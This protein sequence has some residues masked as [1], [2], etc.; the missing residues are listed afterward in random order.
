MPDWLQAAMARLDHFDRF[1]IAA[2]LLLMVFSPWLIQKVT[3][4]S[5]AS[6]RG[7]I[8]I[9][10]L[11]S[12]GLLMLYVLSLFTDVAVSAQCE[13]GP[14]AGCEPL[15]RVSLT[16]LTILV[17]YAAYIVLHA[18]IVRRFGRTRQ[19]EDQKVVSRTY[20]SELFSLLILIG[21]VI[22]AFL[23]V[24]AIWDVQEW[25]RG[26]SVL[27]GLLLILFF[28]KDIWLPDNINGLI[29]LYNNDI[30][31]GSVVRI[32]DLDLLGVVLRTSLLQTT[33]R[34]LVQ[35][36]QVIVPNSRLRAQKV[37]V[38]SRCGSTGLPE[39]VD[40][41]IGYDIP[42]EQVQAMLRE[43]WQEA[44]VAEAAINP[45]VE[46]RIYLAD[47]GD[48]AIS[49]RLFYTVRNVYRIMAARYAINLAAH[50]VSRRHGIGLNTPMTHQAALSGIADSA[51]VP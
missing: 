3:G 12:V 1:V 27:G 48:H 28:T 33:F 37:E 45:E 29:L 26:T 18:W 51:S 2:N 35:R 46:P 44:C 49:W 7:R 31:P 41:K 42:G 36:H 14:G 21:I 47:N 40:F 43:V 23:S 19:I 11:L 30:E 5:D 32:P 16:G 20:Q 9:L 6:R 17:G 22:V 4:L 25:L 34:D 38:L 39:H 10:R 13:A 24:L 50:D 8:L 15:Q